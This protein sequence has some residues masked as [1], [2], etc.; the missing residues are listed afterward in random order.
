MLAMDGIN[1][2]KAQKFRATGWM[3]RR[4]VANKQQSF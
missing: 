1:I 2:A 3:A 4:K